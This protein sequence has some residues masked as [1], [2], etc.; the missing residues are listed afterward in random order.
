MGFA[1]YDVI[2]QYEEI[3]VEIQ[4]DLHIPEVHFMFFEEVIVFDH[5]KQKLYLVGV[6]IVSN[7]RQLEEKLSK[8]KV[9]LFSMEQ[10]R[11]KKRESVNIDH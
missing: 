4:D 8:R 3:G 6:P 1:G 11:V 5:L 7:K 9:E 10:K 2:R